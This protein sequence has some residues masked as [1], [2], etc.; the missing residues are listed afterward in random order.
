MV[1]RTA[2]AAT[3]HAGGQYPETLLTTVATILTAKKLGIFTTVVDELLADF[4]TFSQYTEVELTRQIPD[5]EN[6]QILNGDGTGDNLLGLLNVP[7]LC[8]APREHLTRPWIFSN[9]EL[10]ISAKIST[11][12]TRSRV[13]RVVDSLSP[14]FFAHS[15]QELLNDWNPW[16]GYEPGYQGWQGQIDGRSRGVAGPL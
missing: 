14:N 5:A 15:K 4:Q 10:P 13:R 3:I 7:A 11:A 1:D 16:P 2:S 6:W 12:H 9:R 8:P